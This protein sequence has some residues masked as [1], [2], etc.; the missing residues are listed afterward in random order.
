MED[1]GFQL[2]LRAELVAIGR[3]GVAPEA[4]SAGVVEELLVGGPFDEVHVAI[5]ESDDGAGDVA[6]REAPQALPGVARTIVK[7]IGVRVVAFPNDHVRSPEG[8]VFERLAYGAGG[9]V[10]FA[11]GRFIV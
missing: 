6:P 8:G 4:V 11:I 9:P 5:D 1:G 3:F 2:V 7:E 10:E